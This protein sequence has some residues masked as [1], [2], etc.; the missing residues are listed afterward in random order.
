MSGRVGLLQGVGQFPIDIWDAWYGPYSAGPAVPP[1][2]LGNNL[3]IGM[4][5]Q[6]YDPYWGWGE[7]ILCQFQTASTAVPTGTIVTWDQN[8]IITPVTGAA[9]TAQPVGFVSSNFQS[10]AT[11]GAP[12]APWNQ[13]QTV[14]QLYGW[15]QIAGLCPVKTT[16]TAAV[17][18]M[19]Q[20]ATAGSVS[21]AA[22]VSQ[23]VVN[24]RIVVATGGTWSRYGATTI[25]NASSISG[26]SEVFVNDKD[27]LFVGMQLA[28]TNL[29]A[30]T[31]IT[32]MQTGRNNSVLVSNAA[33]ATGPFAITPS[34]NNGTIYTA[35]AMVNRPFAQGA[36]T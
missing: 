8:Y 34:Y 18:P 11:L 29:P 26:R 25:P 27:G 20:T 30:N 35:L 23:Q 6:S 4:P 31:T 15:V 3:T 33:T 17:G 5:M 36:I 22:V 2:A 9:N 1:T 7:F 14:N 10:D 21:S 13:I 32:D 19:Y 28:G 16:A 24:A 12:T